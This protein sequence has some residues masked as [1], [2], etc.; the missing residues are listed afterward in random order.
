MKHVRASLAVASVLA[1]AALPHCGVFGS[2]ELD[3]I[4]TYTCTGL[5]PDG[6][7]L[8]GGGTE[9]SVGPDGAEPDVV[10]P[11]GCD[12]TAEPKDSAPC[13]TEAVG[14]FVS[15]TGSN[16]GPGTRD[17]P[18]L[19][20]GHAVA[21]A[22]K[23]RVYVCEG[24]Y[25]ENVVV[26]RAAEIYGGFAC[27]GFTPSATKP[28]LAPKKDVAL[29]VKS[30]A[31][32][33]RV[34]DLEIVGS[35]EAGK[36][37]ASAIGVFASASSDVLFRRCVIRAGAANNGAEGGTTS[38]YAGNAPGG[39]NANGGTGGGEVTNTCTDLTSSKGGAGGTSPNVAPGDG[40]A[41]PSVGLANG[42][43]SGPLVCSPGGGGEKGAPG[44]G[45]VA[46]TLSGALDASGWRSDQTGGGG[47]NGNPGQGGG[48]GG[49]KAN[50]GVGGGGGAA[51][52][53]GGGGGKGGVAG[54]SSFALLAYQ[55]KVTVEGG[56]L[57]SGAG[58]KGGKGGKGG[59]G[60][61]TSTPGV[62]G[63]CDGG[64]GG[65]GAGGSGGGGG[66]GGHSMAVAYVGTAPQL[67]N[68][69][70]L[71]A[72]SA[73]AGGDGGDEGQGPG[74]PGNKGDVGGTGTASDAVTAL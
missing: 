6:S 28:K 21:N 18:Y 53:C 59:V 74:N 66:A 34:T 54:G 5:A 7:L 64:P 36:A 50:A 60:Q 55:S 27:A 48:G 30:A 58:G 32:A 44:I 69:A 68:A 20:I 11:V 24:T 9:G 43:S 73:G 23:R 26:D 40:T 57:A 31:A 4:D 47:K 61:A 19:T 67:Q 52:G 13:V 25:E 14:V 71:T 12:L 15:P 70:K 39:I 33:V 46:G 37:G 45:G 16:A 65:A 41:S 10:V 22:G 42:G 17:K 8:D 63:M 2:K 35:A 49:Y 29:T 72:G 56:E 3:C 62:G 51:G 38:N 1:L